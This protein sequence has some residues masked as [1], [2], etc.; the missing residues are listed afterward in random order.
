M[1]INAASM[2]HPAVQRNIEAACWRAIE[3]GA[4]IAVSASG[5]EIVTVI[6]ER[7]EVPA[8]SFWKGCQDVSGEVRAILR[9]QA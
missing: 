1:A 2:R 3:Y 8:L 6:H 5:K 4:A 7:T 9:A